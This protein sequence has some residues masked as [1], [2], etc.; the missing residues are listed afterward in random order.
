LLALVTLP[1]GWVWPDFWTAVILISCGL[2]GGVG[3]VLLTSAYRYADASVVAP[4]DYASMLLALGVGYFGF[5]EVPNADGSAGRGS[6]DRRG[7]PD[8]LARAK[9]GIGACRPAALDDAAGVM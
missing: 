3:Q 1:F 4:F 7:N 9:A 6:G 8:H 5:D 2:L